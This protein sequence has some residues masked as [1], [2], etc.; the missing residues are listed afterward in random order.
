MDRITPTVAPVDSKETR[1]PNIGIIDEANDR[2][3][4]F[5]SLIYVIT[6]EIT[7]FFFSLHVSR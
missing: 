6:L 1:A 4:F 2:L 5:N 7:S 3:S